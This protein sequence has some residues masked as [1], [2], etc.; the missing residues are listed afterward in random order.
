MSRATDSNGR[1]PGAEGDDP[2]KKTWRLRREVHATREELDR[3]VEELG[4]RKRELLDVKLQVRRH[5]AAFT[6]A[7]LAV[8]AVAGGIVWRARKNRQRRVLSGIRTAFGR[9]ASAAPMQRPPE[10]KNR[11]VKL[12]FDA[13]VPLGVALAKGLIRRSVDQPARRTR[14][15]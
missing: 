12:L 13:G 15:G 8:A 1:R 9:L 11:F 7:G 6:A 2:V 14:R 10:E 5:P 3:Y 4:R